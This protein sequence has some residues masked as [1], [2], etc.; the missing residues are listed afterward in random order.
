MTETKQI[1]HDWESRVGKAPYRFVGC[2]SIPAAGS[3]GLNVEGYNNALREC[4]DLARAQGV[5]I[6][7]CDICGMSLTHNYICRN[8]EGR[9]FVVGCD[10]VQHLH[11][12]RLTSEVEESERKRQRTLARARQREQWEAE[13]VVREAKERLANGGLTN[14]EVWARQQAEAQEKAKEK[15]ERAATDNAWIVEVLR[16][17]PTGGDFIPSMIAKLQREPFLELSG[18]CQ[19][20]IGEIWAKE[21]SGSRKNT[22]KYDAALAEFDRRL[23]VVDAD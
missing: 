18:R 4:F 5:S 3:F 16:R 17:V 8:A 19:E 13:R 20:I 6:G 10:C 1:H 12:D 9:G 2:A 7:S 14:A 23:G 22:K 21:T 15:A 11:D